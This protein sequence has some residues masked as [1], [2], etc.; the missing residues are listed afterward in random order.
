[1]ASSKD[2]NQ[3]VSFFYAD[4]N[5]DKTSD[6]V[7]LSNK[8]LGVQSGSDVKNLKEILKH[9]YSKNQTF[10]FAVSSKSLS[11]SLIGTYNTTDKEINLLDSEYKNFEGFPINSEVNFLFSDLNKDNGITLLLNSAK[12]LSAMKIK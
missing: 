5:G 12:T 3:N 10:T 6:L 7:R 4:I 1:M 8:N 2:I 11:K 9:N